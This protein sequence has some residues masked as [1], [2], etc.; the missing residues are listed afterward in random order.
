ML[1]LSGDRAGEALYRRG[2]RRHGAV[3]RGGERAQLRLPR[4]RPRQGAAPR[5]RQEAAGGDS[6]QCQLWI[7]QSFRFLAL[8]PQALNK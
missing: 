5:A 1:L 7:Q 8:T 3:Q 2:R 4:P 6:G